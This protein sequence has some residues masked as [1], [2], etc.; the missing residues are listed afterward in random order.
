MTPIQ[1]VTGR[2]NPDFTQQKDRRARVRYGIKE[3]VRYRR[4]EGPL[5]SPWF[6]G[7]TLNVSAR[8]ILASLQEPL[9]VGDRVEMF[10]DLPGVYFDRLMV[11]LHVT[12]TV[13]RRHTEGTALR[14]LKRRFLDAGPVHTLGANHANRPQRYVRYPQSKPA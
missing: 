14:F 2:R 5:N 9:S 3:S 10:M 8:G 6:R 13:V 11:R 1:K 12:A 7:R 4:S